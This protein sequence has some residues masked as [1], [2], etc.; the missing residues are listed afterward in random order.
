MKAEQRDGFEYEMTTVLDLSH[1]GHFATATKDRTGLFMG[2]DPIV[3][4]PETGKRILDWLESGSDAHT[5]EP[6]LTM[7]ETDI[8]SHLAVMGRAPS[9]EALRSAFGAAYKAAKSIGD[10]AAAKSLQDFY[11]ARKQTLAEIEGAE[12]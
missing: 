6:P 11:E 3:I 5:H 2:R 7:P 1:D 10:A 8:K 4:T 12:A 9:S